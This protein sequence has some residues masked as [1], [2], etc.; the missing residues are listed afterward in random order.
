MRRLAPRAGVTLALAGL[1]LG[2]V[3][4]AAPAAAATVTPT[5]V[6]LV[7]T[8]GLVVD[9][10]GGEPRRAD[11]VVGDGRIL[12]VGEVDDEA[13]SADNVSAGKLI[14]AAGRVVA[15]GFIDPHS[16]GDPF[17]TPAFENFLAMG[18][19]TITLGQ[20]G[21]SPAVED[22]GAWLAA[23]QEQGIGANLAMFVGHGTLREQAG[24]GLA[25]EPTPAQL[26]ALLDR[27]D[28]ALDVSFGLSTGLEYNPGLNAGF[29]EMDS[30]A[31]GVGARNRVI[32]SHL[33]SEDD[34][35]LAVALDE[36]IAQGRHAR[37]HVAHLKS[38]YGKGAERAREILAQ[39]EAARADG[40]AIGADSYPY[41]ASYTGI[42]LLFPEWA[43]TAAGFEA[44]RRE[45]RGELA[46]YLRRRVLARNGPEATLLGTAPFTGRTL[47][48]LA[49]ELDKPFEDVLIDDIGPQGASAAYFVMDEALQ[50]TLLL[51]PSVSVSSD[52]HPSGFHPRGHGAFAKVIQE[53]VVERRL[54][55]LAEAVRKMTSLPATQLGV[56]DRGRIEVGL[57]ADLVVFDPA[58]VRASA[59][60]LAPFQLAEGFDL[61]IVN[62]RI[63][64]RDGALTAERAGRVLR[65]PP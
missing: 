53:Y 38:V 56:N 16:H 30:L 19:T 32:M 2:L 25:P 40:V 6:D 47:A 29:V 60:Y 43:K 45:R 21:S 37:V 65:P 41:T 61:V 27:L 8:N 55:D 44:A 34:D 15:P 12:F 28:R 26:T 59:T 63:A 1:L 52:G 11:V 10:L 4:V 54:L 7:I 62:G 39:L 48:D 36:L 58:Q 3:P 23:L 31:R 14:D 49:Q 9:G 13:F 33:R 22:L 17:A 64:R 20:D 5:P 51:D 18:V 57:A 35:R 50:T 42:A 46:D 24:I